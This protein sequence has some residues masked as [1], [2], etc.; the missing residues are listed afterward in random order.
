ML[1]TLLAWH[2]SGLRGRCLKTDEQW[3]KAPGWLGYIGDEKLPSHIGDS[4]EAL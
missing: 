3:K 1:Q 4:S 2:A